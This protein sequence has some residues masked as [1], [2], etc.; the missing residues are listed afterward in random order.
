MKAASRPAVVQRES[1]Y[2]KVHPQSKQ[3]DQGQVRDSGTLNMTD[4]LRL[5]SVILKT[6]KILKLE[7][8][9]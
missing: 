5:R 7:G 3:K 1:I 8:K 2:G 6:K 4:C 9:A